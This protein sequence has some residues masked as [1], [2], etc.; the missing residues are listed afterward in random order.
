MTA[1]PAPTLVCYRVA[2]S[3]ALRVKWPA[4]DAPFDSIAIDVTGCFSRPPV[5]GAWKADDIVLE[6]H[7]IEDLERHRSGPW[8][9]VEL[10]LSLSP[11]YRRPLVGYVVQLRALSL[12]GPCSQFLRR[13]EMP[14]DTTK[15]VVL[16]ARRTG[17]RTLL[18]LVQ[19]YALDANVASRSASAIVYLLRQSGDDNDVSS[20]DEAASRPSTELHDYDLVLDTWQVLLRRMESFPEHVDLQRWGICAGRA[21]YVRLLSIVPDATAS[22]QGT[23]VGFVTALIKAVDRYDGHHGLVTSSCDV[24]AELF[25]HQRNVLV[26]VVGDRSGIEAIVGTMRLNRENLEVCRAGAQVLILCCFVDVT[27]QHAAKQEGLLPLCQTTLANAVLE[28]NTPVFDL[29]T[30]LELMMQNCGLLSSANATLS[31]MTYPDGAVATI[32]CTDAVANR[33]GGKRREVAAM[34]ITRFF[35]HI[36]SLQRMGSGPMSLLA[37]LHAVVARDEVNEF[38]PNDRK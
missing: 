28:E 31:R 12:T 14:A 6:T 23:F 26:S 24:L 4:D 11:S 29:V 35:R 17:L 20:D 8:Y 10:P 1:L 19:H 7:W 5:D 34:T 2:H 30:C 38:V 9:V 33:V 27:L 15:D 22:L 25:E 32:V 37:V 3:W 36:V 21:L 13:I 16:A 18:E